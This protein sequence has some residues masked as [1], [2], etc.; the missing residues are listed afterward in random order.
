MKNITLLLLIIICNL[1]HAQTFKYITTEDGL[2]N[3]RVYTIKKGHK[4]YMWFLTRDAIDRYDG[5]EIKTYKLQDGFE[6][7]STQFNS[8]WLCTDSKSYIWS[9]NRRGTIHSYDYRKD[10]FKL[11][12]RF[13]IKEGESQPSFTYSFIDKD[14]RIWLCGTHYI[15]IWDDKAQKLSK[16]D[17]N[18]KDEITKV[19]PAGNNK[20]IIGTNN[21]IHYSIMKNNILESQLHTN[22]GEPNIL[23][24]DLF[25]DF[26][27]KKLFIATA[28]KGLFIYAADQTKAED[29]THLLK[30][31]SVNVLKPLNEEELLVA[32]DGEGVFRLN[33][34]D[35]KTDSYL[36]A[37][38]E[39]YNKMNGNTINDLLIDEEDR[40]WMSIFPAGIT[41]LS[42]RFAEYDII[43]HSIGNNNSI[44]NDQVNAVY[45]DSDKDVWYATGNGI[46]LYKTKEN[47][48]QTFLSSNSKP[49]VAYNHIFLTISEVQPGIFWVAGYSSHIFSINKRTGEVG[50]VTLDDANHTNIKPDK[51]IRYI[52]CDNFGDI[53]IGGYQ[54]FRHIKK[55][56]NHVEVL[57]L[58]GS[59]CMIERNADELW[60][61]TRQGLF[62]LNK[63]TKECTQIFLP[64][65]SV[66]IYSLLQD[67]DGKLY[68]GTSNTGLLHYDP[69]NNIFRHYHKNNSSLISD[70]I[71]TILPDKTGRYIV[72]ST[73]MGMSRLYIKDRKI[74]NWTKDQG[75]MITSFNASSGTY[76]KDTNT[77][78]IG[79]NAGAVKFILNDSKPFNYKN[80]LV[81]N[82]FTVDYEL[83][84]PG[85]IDSPLTDNIDNTSHL[86]LKHNQNMFSIKL[87]SINFDYQSDVLYTWRLEGLTEKWTQPG[88][89]NIIRYNS[90]PPGEYTL[91]IK[92]LSRE[93]MD[94]M[95]EERF[96]KI[97]V[98][99]PWWQSTWAILSYLCIAC[100]IIYYI[101]RQ[102][103]FKRRRK[104]SEEKIQFFINSA[105]DIRTPLSLV[106]APLEELREQET[107]SQ[108]GVANMNIAI[109][110]V[111]SL[112]QMT[113][114][115]INFERAELYSNDLYISEHELKSYLTD[116]Y[117]IFKSYG[118]VKR[119]NYVLDLQIDYMNVWFDKGK[120]DSILKNVISN[121]FKYTPQEGTVT[122]KA[123]DTDTTWTVEISDTGIGVPES[124]QK[125]IFKIHF[126]GSNA[127]NSKIVGSGI[128]LML[129]WKLV[130]IHKGKIIFKSKEKEGS[131]FRITFSKDI[132]KLK[133]VH[134]TTAESI[135]FLDEKEPYEEA[136]PPEYETIK[137][138]PNIK[139]TRIL[140]VEDNDELRRYLKHT[141]SDKYIVQTAQ[142]GQ[143]GLTT[144]KAY[145]PELIISDIM[146]PEMRGDEMCRLLKQDI[147]TSHIPIIL[148]TALND[149]KS[150]LKGLN[151][152]A[153]EYISKPFNIS[154]LKATVANLLENRALLR[155]KYANLEIMPEESDNINYSS[156]IDW[157][158]ITMVKK[159]VEDNLD[160]QDFNVDSL[161]NLLNM[162]RTSF[163]NKI[164][165][166][167]SQAPADYIRI[168]RLNRAAELL[169]SGKYSI[170]EI[171]DMT[172]Y[173]DAK[174][175]REVFKKHFNMSPSQYAKEKKN[176]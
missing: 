40:I 74:R 121:A 127:I 22:F 57:G 104:E 174:Y 116:I 151:I 7:L 81:L 101:T 61:G 158:F 155:K 100:V 9:I 140:I 83:V 102:V 147:E 69:T 92:A 24:N 131:T 141:L 97:T 165:A 58:N 122:I 119:I 38:Y 54:S 30:D 11:N 146:M 47:K 41:V 75:L 117:S 133:H 114:N 160:N 84:L 20:Y 85:E 90:I 78:I 94:N 91:R 164:K 93:N 28:R 157:N 2:S 130:K 27:S 123:Y 134:K 142:N 72:F 107:L 49:I 48:W 125:K 166:L 73:E 109:R 132:K 46:S 60:V 171:A 115:L 19:I 110:N 118:Q 154:I 169:K 79:S 71:H 86:T 6:T 152:G 176:E 65:G 88:H 25:I 31:I 55:G 4:G 8:N 149:E 167:T 161:C 150:I 163:Y 168:I 99:K 128:G 70:N 10:S 23:V 67:A 15:Y 82:D 42:N 43:K 108:N 59:T 76:I 129:V 33:L 3:R 173:N 87:S 64:M 36:S 16:I 172:G 98:K 137:Q 136:T 37:D 170:I 124:E 21:G 32:T 175:F 153:D 159:K 126:R 45:E 44:I 12:Y 138:D 113:S 51:Y 5:N 52:H 135:G 39:H 66:M 14:D 143:E 29:Y 13:P 120:M 1:S 112:L 26:V 63:N 139:K 17:T 62:L 145:H 111:N 162:S 105:H 35:Y 96:I 106:K 95:L 56:T 18:I 103:N 80:K 77:F 53:W 156:D 68:I 89:E 50:I 148:L 34:D 144:V